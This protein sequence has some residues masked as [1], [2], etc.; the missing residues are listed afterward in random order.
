MSDTGKRYED[1]LIRFLFDDIPVRGVLLQLS[2]EW[3][4]LAG[5][6]NYEAPVRELLGQ[7]IAAVTAIASTMKFEGMLT[8]QLNGKG[9]LGMLI[10]QCNHKMQMRGMAG[11]VSQT[12][13]PADFV[14]LMGDGQLSMT[15]DARDAKDRYRGIVGLNRD[16]LA[17]SLRDYYRESAQLAAHFVLYA[18]SEQA[19][20][21]MLQRMPDGEEVNADD[22]GRLCLM[23]DTLTPAELRDGVS[24]DLVHK[25]FA[26]D[27]VMVWPSTP[28]TFTC[29]CDDQ[30]AEQAVRMLGENDAIALLKERGDEIE[31]VC[32]FCNTKRTLDAVDVRRLFAPTSLPA[33]PAVH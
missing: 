23:C 18:D 29:R 2:E 10:A 6:H 17:M 5:R 24:N 16:S 22:W 13:A 1:A 19:Y 21:L 7:S 33:D 11:D 27:D 25:L 30:R 12:D 26:E 14:G 31:I 9:A 8:I 4:D 28:L 3:R 32:E 15:V 20:A